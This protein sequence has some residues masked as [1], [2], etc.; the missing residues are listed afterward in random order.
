MSHY[1]DD[2]YLQNKIIDEYFNKSHITDDALQSNNKYEPFKTY[3]T[4][5]QM[6]NDYIKNNTETITVMSLNNILNNEDKTPLL[7]NDISIDNLFNNNEIYLKIKNTIICNENNIKSYINGCRTDFMRTIITTDSLGL[8]N[9]N[10]NTIYNTSKTTWRILPS[11]LEFLNIVIFFFKKLFKLEINLTDILNDISPI[12]NINCHCKK[13]SRLTYDCIEF[14]VLKNIDKKYKDSLY[15]SSFFYQG[16]IG[17]I[18]LFITI[19]V[20]NVFSTIENTNDDFKDIADFLIEPKFISYY[21]DKDNKNLV[22]IQYIN[23]KIQKY[24]GTIIFIP[25]F[26]TYLICSFEIQEFIHIYICRDYDNISK[27]DIIPTEKFTDFFIK[28]MNYSLKIYNADIQAKAEAKAASKA[29]QNAKKIAADK[30]RREKIAV[31]RASIRR[32]GA[33]NFIVKSYKKKLRKTK[34]NYKKTKVHKKTKTY[35]I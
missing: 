26:K 22:I 13:T 27:E 29:V 19:Y 12:H 4:K 21:I 14:N 10:D 31:W 15:Y 20:F 30:N 8:Y 28:K 18:I 2:Y 3:E 16:F 6:I 7:S 25:L 33:S 17:Q 11:E 5:K 34:K 1:N 24:N 35:K 23:I 9:T 32:G